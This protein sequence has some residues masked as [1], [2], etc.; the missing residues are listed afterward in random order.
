MRIGVAQTDPIFGQPKAN[1]EQALALLERQP[2]DL[3]VLPEFFATGYLF[4]DAA[5]A[6]RFAEPIP[7]GPTTRELAAFCHDHA[8][9]VAAG[10][11]E[12]A[13]EGTY[14]AAVLVGPDGL[15]ATYRKIHL[16]ALEKE[17]FLPGDRPFFVVRAGDARVGL[18]VCFDHLFPESA[19]SLALLGAD[20]LAH[21]ANLVLPG[22]GQQTMV[23]RALENGVYAATSNRVG[24]E[25]RGE[26]ELRY[27]GESQ[28][29]G[30]RG[31]VLVR[32]S[33]DRVEAAVVAID[34][35]RA[36]DKSLTARNDKLADR[37]PN[38]Y[39]AHPSRDLETETADKRR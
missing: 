23:V 26:V 25:A 21:P 28:I 8:C 18:M 24:R 7:G 9:F 2:A 22:L 35:A 33:P 19:R 32:L 20:V 5:E 37:R 1:V 15:V 29:V 31:D 38:L 6:A 36:R 12:A 14:N 3:W 16:F 4:A 17:L 13:P 39:A 11:P 30:P 34:L 27:T 10:L